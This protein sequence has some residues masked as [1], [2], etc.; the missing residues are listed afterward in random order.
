MRSLLISQPEVT[1]QRIRWGC[2]EVLNGVRLGRLEPKRGVF[3]YAIAATGLRAKA[4]MLFAFTF[5]L[6]L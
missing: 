5:V 6:S 1:N 2:S 4:T 3:A